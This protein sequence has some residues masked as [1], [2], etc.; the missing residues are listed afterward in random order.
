MQGG[1]EPELKQ[2]FENLKTI[3]AEKSAA[4]KDVAKT[5]VFIRDDGTVLFSD[6][7]QK[8]N[9]IYTAEFGDHR[10]A[11]SVVAVSELP[12]GAA[13]EMEAWAWRPQ[14]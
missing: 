4:L 12:L 7:F 6:L 14:S 3:L 10:P 9:Q 11:R 13:V 1:F 8:L 2:V 5:T